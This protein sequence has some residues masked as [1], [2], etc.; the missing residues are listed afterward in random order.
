MNNRPSCNCFTAN[1]SGNKW[2]EIDLHTEQ[3]NTDCDAWKRLLEFVEIVA[4]DEREEFSPRQAMND[5]EWQQI[6]TLPATISKLKSVKHLMLYGS[7]SIRIPAEIGEM[8]NLDTFTPYTSHRLHWFPYEITRCK[9]LK[10]STVSTRTLYGNFKFRPPFP[11]IP[12]VTD[13]FTKCSVCNVAIDNS[14]LHQVWISLGVATDVLP[15]LVNACSKAC[16]ERLPPPAK[17]YVQKPHKGG[18]NIQQP[19]KG[20]D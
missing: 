8:T 10:N 12:V 7:H 19:P 9:N 11:R 2:S 20:R 17:G 14:N 15:L 16:I 1:Y 3:Q 4:L 13:S 5:I 6:I 18:L